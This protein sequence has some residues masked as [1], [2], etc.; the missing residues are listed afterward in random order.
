M[1]QDCGL[2]LDINFQYP[3]FHNDSTPTLN[4]ELREICYRMHLPVESVQRTYQKLLLQ[5]NVPIKCLVG[6]IGT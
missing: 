2:V 3:H 6:L 5:Y 1:C 4:P